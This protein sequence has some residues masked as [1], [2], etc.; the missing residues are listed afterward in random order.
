[1][2][3]LAADGLEAWDEVVKRQCEG[4]VAKDENSAYEGRRTKRWIKVKQ[5][6]WTQEDDRWRRRLFSEEVR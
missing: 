3:R 1:M 6:G 4:Y 2:R 5:K